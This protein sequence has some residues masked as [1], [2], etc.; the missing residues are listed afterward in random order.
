EFPDTVELVRYLA[1]LLAQQ[2][3]QEKCEATIKDALIRIEQP[4]AHRQLGMLLARF[5]TQWNQKD[6][7]YTLLDA[8]S[9]KLPDDIPVKRRLLL[10][11]QVIKDPEK[12]QQLVDDIKSLEGEDGWQWQYEQARVWFAADDFEARYPQIVT[13]LQ[14][15]LLA[16][17]SDQAS[18]MLLAASYER[19]GEL[20][21]AIS[22][23][24]EGLSRS[25]D[26]LNIIIPVVAALY[27]AR[28]YDEAEQ[29]LNRASAAKL[30]HPQLQQ[31]QLQSHLR[32]GQLSLASDILQDLL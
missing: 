6:N 8:L 23:Y 24:R 31:F 32:H 11:E 30:Y 25:P 22:T 27:K 17:P 16:N 10:C 19:A 5:Y 7:A 26:D 1:I 21:L 14:G 4:I 29:L 28:E 20:Q 2:G 12:A 13:H 3:N 18:R 9:Q 15:N